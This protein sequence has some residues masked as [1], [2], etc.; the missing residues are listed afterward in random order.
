M[1]QLGM[2]LVERL[3]GAGLGIPAVQERAWDWGWH[4][5]W[6][7]WGAWGIGIMLMMFVF[8]LLVLVGFVLGLRWL[9]TQG[10]ASRPDAAL[11]RFSSA[12]RE[13]CR[14]ESFIAAAWWWW[15]WPSPWSCWSAPGSCCGASC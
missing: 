7:L 5:M 13:F 6:G 12:G 1:L 2:R 4:P 8:W 14:R 15:S 10:K 11:D 9:V 3:G